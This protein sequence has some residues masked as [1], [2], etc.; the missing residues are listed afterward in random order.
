M[1]KGLAKRIGPVVE[2]TVL[3]TKPTIASSSMGPL[4]TSSPPSAMDGR[5]PVRRPINPSYALQGAVTSDVSSITSDTTFEEALE[6]VRT[7][8]D[9]PLPLV[10]MWRDIEENG[11]IERTKA[12]G[13][14]G[15]GNGTSL[16]QVL[17]LVLSAASDEGAELEYVVEGGLITI[18]TEAL[19]LGKRYSSQVY[20]V[21]ELLA[22][23]AMGGGRGGRGGFGQGGFGQGGGGYG[24]GGFGQGGFGQGGFGQGGF[25]QGGFGQGGFGQGGYGNYGGYGSNRR[26]NRSNNRRSGRY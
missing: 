21:S 1:A 15:L 16:R 9:P 14:E 17:K 18:A 2:K 20:D 12:I 4:L 11:L 26:N 8:V 24:Q 22:A 10:V 13:I 7:S 3:P 23:P 19:G 25:G 6:I 5:G